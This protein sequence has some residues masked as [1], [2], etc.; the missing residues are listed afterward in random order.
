MKHSMSLQ[1]IIMAL[2]DYWNRHGCLLM[3]PYD[4][5]SLSLKLR[6]HQFRAENQEDQELKQNELNVV[7]D[8]CRKILD[9][10]PDN[11]QVRDLITELESQS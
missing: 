6:V 4:V 1:N 3:N 7:I 5:E 10:T 2:H 8:C 11:F 9:E